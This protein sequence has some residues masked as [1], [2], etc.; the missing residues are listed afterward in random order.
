MIADPKLRQ[1]WEE[2]AA[3][4]RKR[5]YNEPVISVT[6]KNSAQ[7]EENTNFNAIFEN[8]KDVNGKRA[9]ALLKLYEK[10]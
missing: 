2:W 6:P 5:L 1:E 9:A 3:R 4:M 8:F 7:K 10:G